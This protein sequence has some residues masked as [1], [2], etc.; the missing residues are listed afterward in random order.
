MMPFRRCDST[1]RPVKVS[2]YLGPGARHTLRFD[3]LNLSEI[4]DLM[5]AIRAGEKVQI[6]D[7]RRN[8]IG[9]WQA[10]ELRAAAEL[11]GT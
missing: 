4:A 3:E 8:I 7:F 1:S 9:T 6:S 10:R 2:L 5:Q 11:M